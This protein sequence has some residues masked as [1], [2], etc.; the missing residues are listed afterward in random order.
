MFLTIIRRNIPNTITLLNLLSGVVAILLSFRFDTRIGPLPGYQWAF[1]AL[2]AAAI[3]D[4]LDG[5][6]A[7]L[8]R[9]YSEL[10]KQLD[11]LSDLVSFGVAPA[12]LL[13]NALLLRSGGQWYAYSALLI[14]LFGAL[15]LA[16]FNI[17]TTQSVTFSG[18]P[19]PASAIFWIGFIAWIERYAAIPGP[20]TTIALVLFVS[21]LEVSRI[22]MFSLKFHN[23]ALAENFRRYIII[24]AAFIFCTFYGVSGLMWVI[25]L[26][27]LISAT[28]RKQ[29]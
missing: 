9:S 29:P 24:L 22:R 1:I 14:P 7:R 27:I 8:L 13:L 5:A 10:G 16:K 18:L 15:R 3:F 11:S 25:V 23:F 19:I 4:F 12:M 26:Y 20:A 21:L 6:A 17:D 28:A 2:G